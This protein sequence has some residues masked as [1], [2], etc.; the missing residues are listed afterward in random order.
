[1]IKLTNTR[2]CRACSAPIAFIRS[3]I[4]SR[5][6]VVNPDPVII[7][8]EMIDKKQANGLT[9]ITQDG[10]VRR[11]GFGAGEY[12]Y[13]DHHATCTNPEAFRKGKK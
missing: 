4:S 11:G 8:Q 7:T 2:P 9:L 6:F 3:A 1:M 13:V 10:H 5:Y 12:G